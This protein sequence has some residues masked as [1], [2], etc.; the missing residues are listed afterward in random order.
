MFLKEEQKDNKNNYESFIDEDVFKKDKYQGGV[1]FQAEDEEKSF[2]F[3]ILKISST[4]SIMVF[5]VEDF[6]SQNN[7]IEMEKIDTIQEIYLFS[8]IVDLGNDSCV[9]PNTTEINASR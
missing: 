5:F 2:F 9:N 4:E 3:R 1:R 7:M 6:F 8:M